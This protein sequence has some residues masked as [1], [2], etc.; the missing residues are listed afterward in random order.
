MWTTGEST[1][2]GLPHQIEDGARLNA[3]VSYS[4]NERRHKPGRDFKVTGDDRQVLQQIE[5]TVP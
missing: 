1:V 3:L 5:L 2:W 4:W